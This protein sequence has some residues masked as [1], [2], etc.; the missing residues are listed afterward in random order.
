MDAFLRTFI[1]TLAL[2]MAFVSGFSFGGLIFSNKSCCVGDYC[3]HGD[4]GV[5]NQK[6]LDELKGDT[7]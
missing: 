6:C 5:C 4:D 7:Q 3:C 2:G 1:P